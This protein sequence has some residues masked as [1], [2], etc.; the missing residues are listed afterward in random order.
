VEQTTFLRDGQYRHGP[1]LTIGAEVGAFAGINGDVD[2]EQF[3]GVAKVLGI[4]LGADAHFFA[5]VEHGG[6]V[7]LPF[8]N[9]DAAPHVNLVHALTHG[10][11]G[12]FVSRIFSPFPIQRADAIAACSTTSIISNPRVLSTA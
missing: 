10:L 5:D 7:P 4:G 6:I 9:H 1:R 12:H 2:F 3:V 8:A 11:Y